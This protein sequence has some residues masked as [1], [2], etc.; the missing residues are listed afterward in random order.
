MLELYLE[1]IL[2]AEVINYHLEQILNDVYSGKSIYS[3][4][5][6]SKLLKRLYVD[7]YV[8]SLK[9]NDDL[10][11]FIDIARAIISEA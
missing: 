1:L 5:T 6:I 10:Q 3:I 8:A 4:S 9:S 2:L 11:K 7:N